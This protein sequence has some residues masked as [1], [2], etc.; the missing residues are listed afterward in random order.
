MALPL[1]PAIIGGVAT[2]GGALIGSEAS[3]EA[4]DRAEREARLMR[5]MLERIQLP[6]IEKQKLL[7][8][9]PQVMGQYTPEMEQYFQL[10]PSA[11]EGIQITP[12]FQEAQMAALQS[13]QQQGEEGLTASERAILNQIRRQTAQEEQ[14]R[15]GSILQEMASRGVGGSGV[16]LAARLSSS[17]AATERA[18]AE[19]DRLAAMEQQRKLAALQQAGALAGQVRGQEFGE[20]S[21]AARARDVINQ[22]NTAQ[23]QALESRN[24][25]SRNVAQQQN[26]QTQQRIAEQQAAMRNQQQQYN[27]ALQ[28]QQ[29][30]NELKKATG[31]MGASQNL[32]SI[33][34]QQASDVGKMWAGA[35]TGVGQVAGGIYSALADEKKK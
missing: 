21:E 35:G 11:Y 1:L 3:R 23:R 31:Q 10:G 17:Q 13:L 2:V 32:Q 25:G 8:E 22:F 28:Q 12:E 6:D 27:K 9:L 14:A 15:Q 4:G 7:L 20:K 19:S 34:Q 16:E 30:E 5:E 26:L 24:I 33:Y 29:F 18:A